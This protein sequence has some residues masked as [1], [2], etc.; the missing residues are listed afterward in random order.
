MVRESDKLQNM[1]KDTARYADSC[2]LAMQQLLICAE[3]L[4]L[5]RR[6]W[7][8]KYG[9]HEAADKIRNEYNLCPFFSK[10]WL[11][12]QQKNEKSSQ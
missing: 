2:R 1:K 11:I 4:A 10:S 5:K 3:E 8:K 9:G 6:N 12:N 7:R